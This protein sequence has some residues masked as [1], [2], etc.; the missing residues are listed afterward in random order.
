MKNWE[1]AES[2][3][4]DYLKGYRV[5]GSGNKGTR[6]DVRKKGYVVEVK[7]TDRN[8]ISFKDEWMRELVKLS[9]RDEVAI[10]LFFDLR[11][12][13][14]FYDGIDFTLD[15]TIPWKTKDFTEENL[16]ETF[17]WGKYRWSLG[18]LQDLRH[19]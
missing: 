7:Q 6:G 5:S 8:L 12:Y 2:V 17:Y 15:E 13:I 14:Y 10:A 11:G 9:S 19:W 18:T 16:P 1:K 3:V 4:A